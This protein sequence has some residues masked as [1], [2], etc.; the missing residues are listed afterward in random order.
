MYERIEAGLTTIGTATTGEE[1]D[2]ISSGTTRVE[3]ET[4]LSL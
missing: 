4:G 2:L 3:V 1:I